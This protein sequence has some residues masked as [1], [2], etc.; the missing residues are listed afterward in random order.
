MNIFNSMSSLNAAQQ[1][2][3]MRGYCQ[4]FYTENGTERMQTKFDRMVCT[5]VASL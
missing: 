5:V 4:F 3:H 2:F 1:D